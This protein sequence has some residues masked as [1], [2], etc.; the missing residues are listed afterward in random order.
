[1]ALRLVADYYNGET[2]E[3]DNCFWDL[4]GIMMLVYPNPVSSELHIDFKSN[5]FLPSS[6]AVFNGLGQPVYTSQF[7]FSNGQL[8]INSSDWSHGLYTVVINTGKK[9]YSQQFVK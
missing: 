1:M 3:L 7:N 4:E 8:T 9:I 6:V 2:D 5:N